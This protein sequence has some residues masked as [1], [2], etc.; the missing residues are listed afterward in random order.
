MTTEL[1]VQPLGREQKTEPS[2]LLSGERNSEHG[3]FSPDGRL[4]AY[5][6]NPA[7]RREVFVASLRHDA[8][9]LQAERGDQVSKGG[10]VSPRWSPDGRELFYL[11][12]DGTVMAVDV[13]TDRGFQTGPPKTLFQVP[14]ALPD[15]GVHPDRT[16]FLLAVTVRP[17]PPFE[18]VLD[19]VSLFGR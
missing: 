12:A 1:W 11:T 7:G 2:P 5:V 9:S 6:A 4:V 13:R 15:W 3:Q 18:V 10:G 17:S 16:R 14:G 19:G 8:D